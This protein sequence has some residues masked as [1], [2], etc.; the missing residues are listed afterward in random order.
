M[1]ILGKILNEVLNGHRLLFHNGERDNLLAT[2][3]V[4]CQIRLFANRAGHP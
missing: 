4:G 1:T 3:M 2:L